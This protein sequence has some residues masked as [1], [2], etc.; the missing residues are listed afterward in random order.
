MVFCC[1]IAFTA[2]AR[3]DAGPGPLN[4]VRAA[5]TAAASRL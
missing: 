4:A 1:E 2:S 3:S 5:G